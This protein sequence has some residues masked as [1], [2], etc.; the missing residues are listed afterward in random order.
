MIIGGGVTMTPNSALTWQSMKRL[1]PDRGLKMIL[2]RPI[3]QTHC[4]RRIC[5]TGISDSFKTRRIE[6]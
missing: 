3:A 5:F 6:R 1:I 2:Y 4:Q